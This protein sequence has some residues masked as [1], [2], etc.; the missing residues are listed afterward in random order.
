MI[1][2]KALLVAL[3]LLAA[4]CKRPADD[5]IEE[6][7][8]GDHVCARYTSGVVECWGYS[9]DYGQLGRG[10]ADERGPVV[11]RGV[12]GATAIAAESSTTCAIVGGGE[13]E[14]WGLVWGHEG[15]RRQRIPGVRGAVRLIVGAFRG[16]AIAADG[17][18]TCWGPGSK[19]DPPLNGWPPAK[20][21]R[22][23]GARSGVGMSDIFCATLP[24][25]LHCSIREYFQF[26]L[27]P[28]EAVAITGA[29]ARVC[30]LR[31]GVMECG[32]VGVGHKLSEILSRKLGF[33]AL[34]GAGDEICGILPD[35]GVRCTEVASMQTQEHFGPVSGLTA[36]LQLAAGSQTCALTRE[37]KVVC[38]EWDWKHNDERLAQPSPPFPTPTLHH[39]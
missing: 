32:D 19:D 9:N 7:A 28:A 6:I 22:F 5:R 1:S 3:F 31:K 4:A 35:G 25:R 39:P 11:V 8:V 14:C 18:A 34:S 16:C 26:D 10:G 13:V 30:A 2:R 23:R 21:E 15:R 37:H 27:P 38:W 20:D 33:V 29:T 36:P 17:E 24:D 12:S